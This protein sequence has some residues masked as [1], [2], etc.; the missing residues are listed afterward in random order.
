[1]SK[2]PTADLIP[3]VLFGLIMVDL[4]GSMRRFRPLL[5]QPRFKIWSCHPVKS[6]DPSY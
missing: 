1:M 4:P 6:V 5:A 2:E 3:S